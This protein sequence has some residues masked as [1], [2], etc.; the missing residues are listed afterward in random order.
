M[1]DRREIPPLGTE[2]REGER[3]ASPPC[4]DGVPK[5]SG[6][7]AVHA[8]ATMSGTGDDEC[9]PI[10]QIPECV[11]D[12]LSA[13]AQSGASGLGGSKPGDPSAAAKLVSCPSSSPGVAASAV[14]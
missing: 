13:T 3:R 2:F 4:V 8:A 10:A 9:S 11:A 5:R 7:Y 14:A 6:L 12:Q 1:W